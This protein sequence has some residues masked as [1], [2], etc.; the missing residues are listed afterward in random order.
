M[1]PTLFKKRWHVRVFPYAQKVA[2]TQQAQARVQG[3]EGSYG[4][5]AAYGKRARFQRTA[6]V[7][8]GK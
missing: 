5:D 1:L 4:L 7:H 3:E 6:S 8:A 2:L